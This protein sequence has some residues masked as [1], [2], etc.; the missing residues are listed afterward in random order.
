MHVTSFCLGS[1]LL[2]VAL[3]TCEVALQLHH[4]EAPSQ[5]APNG[6]KGLKSISRDLKD[7]K[8]CECQ[9]PRQ[10]S[11]ESHSA[12]NNGRPNARWNLRSCALTKA[13]KG[14]RAHRS[15]TKV[16]ALGKVEVVL[17][18]PPLV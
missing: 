18:M 5:M 8:K 11:R 16:N 10:S 13:K 4:L 17:S 1:R 12:S 9:G 14:Q 2:C 15:V 7:V 3:E 6:L